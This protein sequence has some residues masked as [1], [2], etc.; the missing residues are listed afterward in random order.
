MSAK[1]KVL[2]YTMMIIYS[3]SACAYLF[4]TNEFEM[5]KWSSKT[6]KEVNENKILHFNIYTK[7]RI[8]V[9]LG[10]TV[11]E[12][13][14][15]IDENNLKITS[16]D[17]YAQSIV[18]FKD[19]KLLVDP[20]FFSIKTEE[21]VKEIILDM[22]TL[23]ASDVKKKDDEN[24]KAVTNNSVNMNEGSKINYQVK[25]KVNVNMNKK[26]D[27]NYKAGMNTNPGITNKNSMGNN[28]VFKGRRQRNNRHCKTM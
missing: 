23:S 9:S 3:M 6:G 5:T 12:F 25:Q 4:P 19:G 16:V 28:P 14:Y 2:F 15:Y 8:K 21:G 11:K 10:K 26:V 13:L 1:L 22:V 20:R 7:N 24:K 27:V 18:K 17:N